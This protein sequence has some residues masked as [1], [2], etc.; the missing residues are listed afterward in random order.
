MRLSEAMARLH[1]DEKIRPAYV[2]EVCRLL[3][4]SNIKIRKTD[5]E[6]DENQDN[7]NKVRDERIKE[8]MALN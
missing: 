5:I 6:L 7:L 3:K 4:A 2:L 8:D 1:C